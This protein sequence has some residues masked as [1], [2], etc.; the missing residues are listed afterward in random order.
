MS[1]AEQIPDNMAQQPGDG[2]VPM[3]NGGMDHQGVAS[4]NSFNG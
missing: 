4:A 1:E 3:D 2:G